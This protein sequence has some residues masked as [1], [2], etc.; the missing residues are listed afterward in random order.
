MQA[1]V[2]IS[3]LGDAMASHRRLIGRCESLATPAKLARSFVISRRRLSEAR[4]ETLSN[5]GI[6]LRT[7]Y[8]YPSSSKSFELG[9]PW[10]L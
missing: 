5:D 7:F 6:L 4:S 9:S 2:Q 8:G 10:M 1:Q 3:R